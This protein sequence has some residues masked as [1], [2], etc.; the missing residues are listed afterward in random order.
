MSDR[1]SAGGTSVARTE[2]HRVAE[3]L[4]P[5][6]TNVH[7]IQPIA[8]PLVLHRWFEPGGTSIDEQ[9][10]CFIARAGIAGATTP[11]HQQRKPGRIQRRAY[12]IGDRTDVPL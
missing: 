12:S 9:L 8:V 2:D 1:L 3:I 6:L 7:K 5:E 10:R 4:S 11:V